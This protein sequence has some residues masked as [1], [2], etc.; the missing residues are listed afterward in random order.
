MF[1]WL[2]NYSWHRFAA[3]EVA[4]AVSW[5]AAAGL[6]ILLLVG[7]W[8]GLRYARVGNGLARAA[9]FA[10]RG[11][12]LGIVLITL[13]DPHLVTPA[14]DVRSG[15]V[16]VVFD[17]S[18]SMRG[19]GGSV[20]S[21][22]SQ[23]WAM[24]A[25]RTGSV[26]REIEE[27]FN[28][29]Y[30]KAGVTAQRFDVKA[31]DSKKPDSKKPDSKKPDSKTPD[32]KNPDIKALYVEDPGGKPRFDA[33]YTD[34][35]AGLRRVKRAVQR[36]IAV[37]WVGDGGAIL[38]EAA[39]QE[40]LALRS[41]GAPVHTVSVGRAAEGPDVTV[42]ALQVPPRALVGDPVAVKA[43]LRFSGLADASFTSVPLTVALEDNGLLLD[44]RTVT[45]DDA[46]GVADVRFDFTPQKPGPHRLKVSVA[47]G[48]GES[49]R[50]NNAQTRLLHVQAR[51]LRVLHFESEPR[52]EV[53]FA[54]RALSADRYV[55][56]TSLVRTAENK[57]Y[58]LGVR[59]ADE[60][61]DGFPRRQSALFE[62]DVVVLGSVAASDLDED[63][64]EALMQFVVRRGGSLLM[65]GGNRSLA[66]GGWQRTRL[67]R[68]LPV[69]L[70]VATTRER[71]RAKVY[72]AQLA[73]E[74]S[75]TALAYGTPVSKPFS[76]LPELSVVNALTGLKPGAA[77]YWQGRTEAGTDVVLLAHHRFGRGNIAVLPA[78]DL[79]RCQM[80][81]S[82]E[83]DDQSHELLWQRMSRWLGA[84][85]ARRLEVR[86]SPARVAPGQ[87][88]SVEAQLVDE[89]Y[90][91]I[92]GAQLQL[93][94]GAPARGWQQTGAGIYRQSLVAAAA[95]AHEVTVA[96]GEGEARVE[97]SAYLQVEANGRE[98]ERTGPD[99][100]AMRAIA[101]AGRGRA[102]SAAT[103]SELPQLLDAVRRESARQVRLPLWNAWAL[104]LLAVVLASTEWLLRKRWELV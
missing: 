29:I 33:P 90:R 40:M 59:S 41:A 102:L 42:T 77:L 65:L 50:R 5:P 68:A 26:S 92:D 16:A 31:P 32:N 67:G 58:R 83:L 91:P 30:V 37:V 94:G 1:E 7:G 53:K 93:V 35:A 64:H 63:Q 54:R 27:R 20:E 78:R 39:R 101:Q 95:G 8:W 38:D 98:F 74:H 56:L 21:A 10:V 80:H 73:R 49:I 100:A 60:L 4:L 15:S 55:L 62:Y 51:R 81:A 46:A 86:L 43:K 2:F 9:L 12:L 14:I 66:N 72:P 61:R 48:A 11:L 75:V 82:V 96:F 88:L 76:E 69:V 45:P 104:L 71:Y 36:P 25:P 6:L 19:A 3:G 89:A 47:P 85:A 70:P 17:D 24:F 57:F 52:F 23:A 18:L 99:V 84:A 28:V 87:A 13:L 22:G 44:E 79:W 34:L 103:A 97:G